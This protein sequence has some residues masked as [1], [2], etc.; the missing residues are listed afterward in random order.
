MSEMV[1]VPART[2]AYQ[3]VALSWGFANWTF[4]PVPVRVVSYRVAL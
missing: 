4:Q 1:R 2:I 3:I